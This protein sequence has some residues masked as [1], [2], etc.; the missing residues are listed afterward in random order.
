MFESLWDA[1]FGQFGAMFGV[2][3]LAIFPTI[4]I[5]LLVIIVAIVKAIKRKIDRIREKKARV[6]QQAKKVSDEKTVDALFHEIYVAK[7]KGDFA[8]AYDCY[9][10]YSNLR[11]LDADDMYD[12]GRIC[13][14]G[15]KN[16]WGRTGER[17]NALT[18]YKK[19]ADGGNLSAKFRLARNRY[20]TAVKND[21]GVAISKYVNEIRS[22]SSYGCSDAAKMEREFDVISATALR[23]KKEG[24]LETVARYGANCDQFAAAESY[25]NEGTRESIAKALDWLSLLCKKGYPDAQYLYGSILLQGKYGVEKDVDEGVRWLKEAGEDGDIHSAAKLGAHFYNHDDMDSA[26]YWFEKGKEHE[27]PDILFY[28]AIA[29]IKKKDTIVPLSDSDKD[30]LEAEAKRFDLTFNYDFYLRK[31]AYR[32]S[33]KAQKYMKDHFILTDE[34]ILKQV[35]EKNAKEEKTKKE[36]EKNKPLEESQV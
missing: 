30:Y 25:L 24:Y 1:Y 22:L 32:G 2:V 16:G 9:M 4:A 17:Y 7:E 31:A 12:I 3:L 8:K 5:I 27:N 10:A 23:E 14:M 26:I 6:A 29:Y 13:E 15:E 28:L 33:L 21:D 18:W 34:E 36:Q 35:R 19:S 20:E 11:T